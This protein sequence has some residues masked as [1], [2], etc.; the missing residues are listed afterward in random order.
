MCEKMYDHEN[1]LIAHQK[2]L[3]HSNDPVALSFRKDYEIEMTE[4]AI[5]KD[6]LK[7]A[8]TA[9]HKCHTIIEKCQPFVD[10][11]KITCR[12]QD[13]LIWDAINQNGIISRQFY[14]MMGLQAIE[15]IKTVEVLWR[16]E[17]CVNSKLDS[18]DGHTIADLVKEFL[19]L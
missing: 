14:R 6:N 11:A 19:K 15:D 7:T 8:N 17:C 1:N 18:R 10:L 12:L 4:N 2:E 3:E 16:I 13:I 9:I 5:L